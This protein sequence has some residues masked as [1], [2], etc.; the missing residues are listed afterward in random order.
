VEI[1]EV[2]RKEFKPHEV[3]EVN[4]IEL[5]KV[6]VDLE[7]IK[8][9]N[10][11]LIKNNKDISGDLSKALDLVNDLRVKSYIGRSR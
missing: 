2:A 4:A 10:E 5:Q 7:I 3:I 11:M 1:S 6:L 8:L 9:D